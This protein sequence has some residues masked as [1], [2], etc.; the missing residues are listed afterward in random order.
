MTLIDLDQAEYKK[1][2]TKAYALEKRRLQ[3]ELLKLQE[4]V[5]K[6]DRKICIVFEGRDTAGKS[7]AIKFFSEYLRPNNFN[8]I[9]LGIPSKWESSHWFQRWEKVLPEK[10]EISFLDRS[11]YTRAVTEPIMGYC[12]E[13]QYRTF[14]KRV[15]EWE[16]KLIKNGTE[17]TKFYFSLSKDQ[18][19]RRMNARK[20]SQLKYWKLS[21]NDEKI[22]TKWDAFTLYKEQMFNKTATKESPWVSINSNNKMIGR[23]T[24]LRYLLIKTGYENKKILKPAKYSKG[25]SNYSAS[26]EG[27]KFDNL[28]YE[29]FMIITKYS[30]DT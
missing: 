4:D 28:T 6:N 2:D 27:V 3:I 26:I 5:I 14:M 1:L 22:V 10:G 9:Q 13:R 17:L 25:L 24:S 19:E 20:N 29:Q 7:S 11:W 8:Y 15:N 12:N 30:D 18:Q 16:S 21:K 23:L